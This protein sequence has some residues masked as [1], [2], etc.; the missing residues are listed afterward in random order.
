MA[1]SQRRPR[2]LRLR[3]PP[4]GLAQEPHVS[5]FCIT[6]CHALL[7]PLSIVYSWSCFETVSFITC[8]AVYPP[9]CHLF[10]V[11]DYVADTDI[12]ELCDREYAMAAIYKKFEYTSA[13]EDGCR[14][15]NLDSVVSYRSSARAVLSNRNVS[16]A[17]I[18]KDTRLDMKKW[19]ICNRLD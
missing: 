6:P 9:E 19:Y 5:S 18:P 3:P 13:L 14:A 7:Q 8:I 15:S 11:A 10:L 12:P 17:V 1:E 16:I 2:L 4:T